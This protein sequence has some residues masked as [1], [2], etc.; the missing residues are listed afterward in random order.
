MSPEQMHQQ[1]VTPGEALPRQLLQHWRQLVL[2]HI[3]QFLTPRLG[4]LYNRPTG[5]FY[6]RS[7]MYG[8]FRPRLGELYSRPLGQFY[9][10]PFG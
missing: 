5:Q 9:I 1:S 2:L 7:F 6:I 3:W 4:E 10:L 8:C